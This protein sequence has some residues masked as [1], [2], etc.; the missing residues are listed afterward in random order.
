MRLWA[1]ALP[2]ST[3]LLCAYP[4]SLLCLQEIVHIQVG[5]CGN[6]IGSAFWRTL[7]LEHGI[8]EVSRSVSM[9]AS[10]RVATS[11]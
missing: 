9:A 10:A 4:A 11:A 2:T 5:Q 6:Q 8:T 1:G 7:C 3:A